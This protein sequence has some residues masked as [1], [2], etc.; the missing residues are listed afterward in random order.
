MRLEPLEVWFEP[1]PGP[2]LPQLQSFLAAAAGRQAGPSAQLL[3]WAITA[4]EAARGLKIEAMLVVE[5]PEPL[6]RQARS[7]LPSPVQPC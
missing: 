4:S 5:G 2:L 1:E 7:P 3:R 6:R